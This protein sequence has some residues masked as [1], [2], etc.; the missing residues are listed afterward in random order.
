MSVRLTNTCIPVG[1]TIYIIFFYIWLPIESHLFV[2]VIDLET[3][4]ISYS[5]P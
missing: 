3:L 1:V 4:L 5:Q 2:I